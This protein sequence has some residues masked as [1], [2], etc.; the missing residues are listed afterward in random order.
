M[1]GAILRKKISDEQFAK[2]FVSLVLDST[3]RGFGDVAQIINEDNSFVKPPHLDPEDDGK[4]TLIVMAG[5]IKLLEKYFDNSKIA[6]IN[7]LIYSELAPVYDFTPEQMKLALNQYN[8]FMT[9]I[10]HPSKNTLYAMSKA[11]F[12]KYELCAFQDEY[13]RNMQ[14]PNPLF[15]KRMDEIMEKFI[16][17]WDAYFKKFKMAA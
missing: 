7:E 5:N 4:F 15:L 17:N 11:V 10:N 16:L 9:R 12:Y 1:L 13:F 6:Y 8:S 3:E 2:M 14:C